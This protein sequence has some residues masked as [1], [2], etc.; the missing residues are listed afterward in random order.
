MPQRP[1]GAPPMRFLRKFSKFALA[2]AAIC[3][4]IALP[5]LP[6]HAQNASI[7]AHKQDKHGIAVANM[8]ASVKPGD[9]FYRYANDALLDRTEIPH[10]R[11]RVS[12]FNTLPDLS[13]K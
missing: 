5:L 4:V 13:N 10:D 9:D 8:G 6:A 2:H 7:D 11:G 3:A 1:F 12:L